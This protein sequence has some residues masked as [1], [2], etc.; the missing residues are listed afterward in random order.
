MRVDQC[1]HISLRS[2]GPYNPCPAAGHKGAGLCG[3]ASTCG[4]P[5]GAGLVCS[6]DHMLV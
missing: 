5:T 1:W 6:V 2:H 3:S 4:W